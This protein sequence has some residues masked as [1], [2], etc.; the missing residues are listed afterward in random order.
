MPFDSIIGH[1]FPVSLLRNM[2]TTGRI[3]NAYLFSGIEGIGK[4][5][6]AISFAKA[7]NCRQQT[8]DFC[9]ECLSCHK[10]A[11]KIHPDLFWL[12]PEKNVITVDKIRE[13]QHRIIFKPLE[14]QHKVV[15]IDQA[16]KLNRYAANCLLKT[17]EEP[18][19]D[20]VIILIVNASTYLLPTIISRCQTIRFAPLQHEQIT[21]FL[22]HKDIGGAK[23]ALIASLAQGS[24]KKAMFLL[25]HNFI[26]KR[27]KLLKFLV[28][29]SPDRFE[30]LFRLSS[31]VSNNTEEIPQI[32]EFLQTWYRD[33]YLLKQGFPVAKLLNHDIID[34]MLE[35]VKRETGAGLIKKMKKLRWIQQ[36]LG[37]NLNLRVALES[38]LMQTE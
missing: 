19:E 36:N 22:E 21:S 3:A 9:G 6:L 27:K 34:E 4:C 14:G 13:V 35:S 12:E 2:L 28:P 30:T 20:T 32:L 1:T 5:T 37:A 16:E 8:A 29:A 7:L 18:P 31:Q 24:I 10:I 38:A 17:L 33:L 26:A 23:A 15:I 25:E 11:E